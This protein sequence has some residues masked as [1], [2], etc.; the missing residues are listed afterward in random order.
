MKA[1]V[2]YDTICGERLEIVMINGEVSYYVIMPRTSARN[3]EVLRFKSLDSIILEY[4]ENKFEFS[5]TD[6]D[7]MLKCAFASKIE[8][9]LFLNRQISEIEEATCFADL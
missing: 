9:D 8:Y 6:A 2:I 7:F 5:A 1:I 4:R 3:W